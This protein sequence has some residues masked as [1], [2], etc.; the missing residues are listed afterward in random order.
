[1]F[2]GSLP[3]NIQVNCCDLNSRY[4]Q[5]GST[6]YGGYRYFCDPRPDVQ[7]TQV[8]YVHRQTC[9]LWAASRYKRAM[10][11]YCRGWILCYPGC[12]HSYSHHAW[13]SFEASAEIYNDLC[14]ET[15]NQNYANLSMYL[16]K[17]PLSQSMLCQQFMCFKCIIPCHT[18][19]YTTEDSSIRDSIPS[20]C[21]IHGKTAAAAFWTH[22][23]KGELRESGM[24]DY[25]FVDSSFREDCIW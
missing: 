22:Q 16:E 17:Y 8:C 7:V 5:Y 11:S 6:K 15:K 2:Q 3:L 1:M 24:V 12:C 25:L 13:V 19:M 14:R 21:E 23:L 10:R 9:E 4:D 18:C 20:L